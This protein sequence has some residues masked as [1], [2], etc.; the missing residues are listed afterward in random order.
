MGV[1][2]RDSVWSGLGDEGQQRLINYAA[3]HGGGNPQIVGQDAIGNLTST[4]VPTTGGD[5]DPEDPKIRYIYT[6]PN[7]AQMINNALA[8]GK[9]GAKYMP[10][11]YKGLGENAGKD[12]EAQRDL[13]DK[14]NDLAN[15][16][17]KK[18][19][20]RQGRINDDA[21]Y[22]FRE[23]LQNWGMLNNTQTGPS[24][25]YGSLYEMM[26]GLT[27]KTYDQFNMNNLANFREGYNTYENQKV[28]T[29]NANANADMQNAINLQSSLR[30][31][32]L[33]YDN[34]VEEYI[35]SIFSQIGSY[36]D[37]KYTDGDGGYTQAGKD[38]IASLGLGATVGN[39][40]K[41]HVDRNAAGLNDMLTQALG[42]N[43]LT[44]T[45]PQYAGYRRTLDETNGT[46]QRKSDTIQ[47]TKSQKT[48]STPQIWA[49]L[50]N[51]YG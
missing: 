48:L 23:R 34:A 4:H 6:G 16:A 2:V 46:L 9:R 24:G 30:N 20:I 22:S 26:N 41:I 15:D 43:T 40:G 45:S 33:Q 18:N 44:L 38:Y 8:A 35:E 17:F 13:L 27:N 3:T 21:W 49:E 28:D 31:L 32:G 47:R 10:D 5:T 39:D 12:L 50:E 29:L 36:G 51:R 19:I 14:N 37:K 11:Y 25:R 1:V 42:Y 7:Y